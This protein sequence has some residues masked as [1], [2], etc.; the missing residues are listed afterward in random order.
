MT[1]FVGCEPGLRYEFSAGLTGK[2]VILDLVGP[3][4][5]KVSSHRTMSEDGA[6]LRV[7]NHIPLEGNFLVLWHLDAIETFHGFYDPARFAENPR[8]RWAGI[9]PYGFYA[10]CRHLNPK[11]TVSEASSV[12]VQAVAAVVE[13][14]PAGLLYVTSGRYGGRRWTIHTVTTTVAHEFFRDYRDRI[15]KREG[16]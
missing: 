5:A 12:A 1:I 3:G 8:P 15:L 4:V 13:I 6:L 9:D 7:W 16:L 2:T 14:P 10:C 11:G